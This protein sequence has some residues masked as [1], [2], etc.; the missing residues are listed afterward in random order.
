MSNIYQIRIT[1]VD[2]KP[3]IWRRVAVPG[4]LTLGKLHEVIQIAMGWNDCHL[5]HFFLQDKALKPSAEELSRR[6][7]ADDIDRQFMDRIGGRRFFVAHTTPFGDPTEMEGEDEDAV[8]LGE[9]CPKVKSKI[10]YEY[11]FGD[12]WLHTIEVQKTDLVPEKGVVYPHCLT[13]KRAC[14]PEDCGGVW[15]YE[16]LLEVLADPRHGEYKDVIEW[17]GEDFNPEAF[18]LQ[19]VNEILGK[20]SKRQGGGP[21]LRLTGGGD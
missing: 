12:S 18:D 13:G 2:T 16:R 10:K 4:G 8:T 15:G 1:L 6:V 3:P 11:D 19:E 14:P 21:N 9:L 20:W 17:V 5:H 7:E